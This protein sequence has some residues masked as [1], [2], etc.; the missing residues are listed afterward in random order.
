MAK[1]KQ[2]IVS[3]CG[4]R[5]MLEVI[6]SKWTV[7]LI[8]GLEKGSQRHGELK[9]RV[10]DISEKMLTQ[11]L[12]QMERDGLIHR[13]VTATV[14]PSVSYSLTPLGNSLVP[15]LRSMKA[16]AD[17]NYMLVEQARESY[18]HSQQ[19]AKIYTVLSPDK[20][21]RGKR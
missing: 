13:E 4:Y 11:T 9:R 12:R 17:Q 2:D 8:Y 1:A 5:R 6:A 3:T 15:H 10:Q 16:W 7:L 21:I 14:P 19:R 20:L 18:D